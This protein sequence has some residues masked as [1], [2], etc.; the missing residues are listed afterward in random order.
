MPLGVSSVQWD[1]R[2]PWGSNVQW[3][4]QLWRT[5]GIEPFPITG[6][7]FEYVVRDAPAGNLIVALK[8][9]VP[10]TPVPVGGGL[11]SIVNQTNLAAVN[12]AMYPPATKTLTPPLTYF[13]ALWMDYADPVNATNLFW[14]QWYVD[15]AAQSG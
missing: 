13:H 3:Q 8:S 4:I 10:G 14:G 15:A 6:H 12:L 9:D 11:L 2:I 5:E 7:T 1:L